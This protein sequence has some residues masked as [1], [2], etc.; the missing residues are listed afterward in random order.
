MD[1]YDSSSSIVNNCTRFL[2]FNRSFYILV[3]IGKEND[4][5]SNYSRAGRSNNS[6]CIYRQF[7]DICFTKIR[8][9]S[10]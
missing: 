7:L 2:V 1:N 8:G 10:Y 3:Q 5:F 9:W 6:K 4:V